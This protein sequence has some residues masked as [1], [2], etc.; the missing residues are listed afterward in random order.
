MLN[1][2]P[3]RHAHEG[4][5]HIFAAQRR[6]LNEVDRVLDGEQLSLFLAYCAFLFQIA[7]KLFGL[8]ILNK[9]L[10]YL[11]PDKQFLDPFRGMLLDIA[12]PVG[13]IFKT[14]FRGDVV[15]EENA[16]CAAI[17]CG[18]NCTESLLPGCVPHLELQLKVSG[19]NSSLLLNLVSGQGMLGVKNC[20]SSDL[21]LT[22]M[23][24][25]S[26]SSVC[27][28]KSIPM[29]EM[30]VELNVLSAKRNSKHVLPTPESPISSSLKR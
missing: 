24:F 19:F 20:I 10:K 21:V 27:I 9:Y 16:H 26:I 29:V 23:R 25:P 11:I 13:D 2:D 4:L 22:L 1:L 14:L 8:S 7:L 28:L 6:R 12:Q 3:S 30:N 15:N 5:A 18:C 17:I